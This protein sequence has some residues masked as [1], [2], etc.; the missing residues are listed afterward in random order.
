VTP[1][2]APEV[3]LDLQFKIKDSFMPRI[4]V[5]WYYKNKVIGR[6]INLEKGEN[7]G[8]GILDSPDTQTDLWDNDPSLLNGFP[9]LFGSE[10]FSIPRGRILWDIKMATAKGLMDATLFN[11]PAKLKI[12]QFFDLESTGIQWMRDAHYTTDANELDILFNI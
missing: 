12:L 11:D 5:F 1:K 8:S 9:E 10:Y 6:A 2:R 3:K 7:F 4:G